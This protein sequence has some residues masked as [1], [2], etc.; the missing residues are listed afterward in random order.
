[1]KGKLGPN[2][3]IYNDT[4]CHGQEHAKTGAFLTRTTDENPEA[5]SLVAHI[6]HPIMASRRGI[7][8]GVSDKFSGTPNYGRTSNWTLH[9]GDFN[10]D[11][12]EVRISNIV[13]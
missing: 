7:A 3:Q 5:V 8:S 11:L 9:L 1:L 10:G 4:G 6:P 2:W 12:D 13:R